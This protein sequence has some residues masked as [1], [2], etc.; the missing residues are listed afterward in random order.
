MF[1]K[2]V[3]NFVVLA[4]AQIAAAS[5]CTRTYTVQSGD[6]CDSIS[7]ANH[8]STYQLA[9]VNYPNIDPGCTNLV[10]GSTI[11]L[12][13]E[14]ED[15][16]TTYVV[17]LGDTCDGVSSM[18]YVNNTILYLNN[19]QINADCSNLYVGEVLC[20]ASTVIVP[21]APGGGSSTPSST[22]PVVPPP[23]ATPADPGYSYGDGGDGE[24]DLP[25]CE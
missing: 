1:S 22:V 11:C 3:V 5:S 10:P 15:C 20:T 7:A 8:V 6:I 24:D 21:P 12:G 4:A 9:V 19:P 2:A 25:W 17:Q 16:Q 18:A 14:G 23:S 13:N